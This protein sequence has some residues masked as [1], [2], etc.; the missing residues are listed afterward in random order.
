ME[1][2]NQEILREIQ[3]LNEIEENKEKVIFK[4]GDEVFK[5][6]SKIEE[7]ETLNPFDDY[8]YLFLSQF[9]NEFSDYLKD[10]LDKDIK[11]VINSFEENISNFADDY[12]E[13]YNSE[14]IK[15]VSERTENGFYM[16][17]AINEGLISFENYDFFG[18][19]QTAYSIA[20]E[21]HFI[22]YFE[23]L[24]EYLKKKFKI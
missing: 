10:N 1:N 5:I 17:D 6:F 11:E 9:L 21:R 18:H 19:L 16:E 12:T 15:W 7:P 14:L 4:N 20:L 3:R 13:I 2:I 22:A 8:S 23:S 24:K